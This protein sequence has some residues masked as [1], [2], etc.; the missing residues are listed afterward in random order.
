MAIVGAVVGGGAEFAVEACV[1]VGGAVDAGTEEEVDV[2]VLA[3]GTL[4]AAVVVGAFGRGA[5]RRVGCAWRV[6]NCRCDGA[7]L[8]RCGNERTW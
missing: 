8:A 7:E 3:C 4:A 2:F 6:N 1:R 5:T